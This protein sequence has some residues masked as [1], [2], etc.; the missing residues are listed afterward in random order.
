M[1]STAPYFCFLTDVAAM[2]VF[3]V[4]K[5]AVLVKSQVTSAVCNINI[6][7]GL[8][9]ATSLTSACV[10]HSKQTQTGAP[11]TS[12]SWQRPCTW[13]VGAP[14]QSRP[15]GQ[16]G[17]GQGSAFSSS[18]PSEQVPLTL[19]SAP[20]TLTSPC[21]SFLRP[22]LTR[23]LPSPPGAGGASAHT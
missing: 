18:S 19:Q 9:L 5:F 23:P 12:S 13:A 17:A 7:I 14:A 1:L 8:Q 22:F 2:A 10:S 15:A 16:P 20:Q 6:A 3:V 11:C 4:A 21:P